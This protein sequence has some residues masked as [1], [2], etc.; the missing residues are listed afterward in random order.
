MTIIA[1]PALLTHPR[2]SVSQGPEQLQGREDLADTTQDRMPA[3]L[4]STAFHVYA[5]LVLPI[6]QVSPPFMPFPGR[7]HLQRPFSPWP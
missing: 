3:A 5:S 7:I 4:I 6:L 2:D 1:Q